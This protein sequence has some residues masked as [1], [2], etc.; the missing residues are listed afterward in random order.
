VEEKVQTLVSLGQN[1]VRSSRRATAVVRASPSLVDCAQL[2][3]DKRPEDSNGKLIQVMRVEPPFWISLHDPTVTGDPFARSIP[4][5]ADEPNALEAFWREQLLLSCPSSKS[6]SSGGSDVSDESECA[7]VDAHAGIGYFGLFSLAAAAAGRRNNVV[8]HSIEDK[9]VHNLRLCESLDANKWNDNVKIWNVVPSDRPTISGVDRL[10]ESHSL[11]RSSAGTQAIALDAWAESNGFLSVSDLDV[12]PTADD[13]APRVKIL[14]IGGEA[15]LQQVLLGAQRML[16]QHVA[17]NVFCN[18]NARDNLEAAQ[19]LVGV[20][21]LLEAGYR[22]VGYGDAMQAPRED[23]LWSHSERLV[24]NLV[25]AAQRKPNR[26]LTAWFQYPSGNNKAQKE[27]LGLFED[28]YSSFPGSSAR[29]VAL[30]TIQCE[31]FTRE[32]LA[33]NLGFEDPNLGMERESMQGY[34]NYTSPAFWISLHNQNYDAPRWGIKTSGRYYKSKLEKIWRIILASSR[35]GSHVIDVGSN[36]GYFTLVSLAMGDAFV[37]HAFEPN[38][39]NFLRLC[40]SLQLNR[41]TDRLGTTLFANDGGASDRDAILP[42]QITTDNPGTSHFLDPTAPGFSQMA[43]VKRPVVSLDSYAQRQGWFGSDPDAPSQPPTIAI[44]KIDVEGMEHRVLAGASKLLRSGK[45]H[46][47][48]LELSAKDASDSANSRAALVSMVGAGYALAGIGHW[49]G[50]GYR[51]PW[52][53]GD[54][55]ELVSRVLSKAE[56]QDSK[57]LHV[58]FVV[59]K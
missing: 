14:R 17:E 53:Q 58:W 15:N 56:E 10:H 37:V 31:T 6:D 46:N 13:R 26:T 32:A 1:D 43:F 59:T 7:I 11:Y 44:L 49:E 12:P 39:V 57:Q 3:K 51:V 42:F 41:W 34:V 4:E 22:L 55:K 21:L 48:F 18:V 28:V 33:G 54:D 20:A 19:S 25:H 9:P 38:P 23:V 45:V 50:P 27:I 2:L 36:V 29:P 47:V 5:P 30:P 35:P 24:G 8:V 52:D 16:N 40:E